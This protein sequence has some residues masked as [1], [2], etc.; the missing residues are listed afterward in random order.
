MKKYKSV[1]DNTQ[2]IFKNREDALNH[3]KE[4]PDRV[5][6]ECDE[7]QYYN[8]MAR[9]SSPYT[10]IS[11]KGEKGIVG[12]IESS[13]KKIAEDVGL[14]GASGYKLDSVTLTDNNDG[15][16]TLNINGWSFSSA[17][18]GYNDSM[19]SEENIKK[20]HVEIRDVIDGD[21][22]EG[23]YTFEMIPSK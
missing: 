22:P 13:F 19:V 16:A 20:I 14:A 11:E 6:K 9:G 7:W 23:E 5:Y 10:T 3:V 21:I 18:V 4:N 12:A 8:P 1:K 2:M 17:L 15:T